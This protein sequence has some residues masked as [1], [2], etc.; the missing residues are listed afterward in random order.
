MPTTRLLIELLD[1]NRLFFN[2][3]MWMRLDAYTVHRMV[4]QYRFEGE[5]LS[6]LIDPQPVGTFGHYLAFRWTFDADKAEERAAFKAKYE[7]SD[8]DAV[9]IKVVLPTD[10]V[11]AEAVLGQS[12]AAEKID[13]TRFW[14][15]ADSPIPILPPDMRPVGRTSDGQSIL[16][17]GQP[18]FSQ[19]LPFLQA[20][21]M[22]QFAGTDVAGVLAALKEAGIASGGGAGDAA[23]LAARTGEQ[24]AS[25]AA[26]AT[27]AA[28]ETHKNYTKFVT[29]L[30][31]SD[32]VKTIATTALPA[33]KG[34][35]L[36]GGLMNAGKSAMA[37]KGTGGG[38]D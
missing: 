1:K 35:S 16:P 26:K 30:A 9:T 25:G 32:L 21:A 2:Q 17:T 5:P 36:L 23:A 37:S 10:G 38:E 12:N 28:V 24:A 29:D 19:P 31:N 22:P 15:W 20:P 18:Q 14:N 3:Q 4:H 33:G 34:A 11:F 8:N 7:Q 6:G 13:L 27:D